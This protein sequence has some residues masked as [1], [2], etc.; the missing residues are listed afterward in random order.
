MSPKINN[1]LKSKDLIVAGAFAALYVIL[2][3][4]IVGVMGFMVVTYLA[5]PFV[6]GIVL[7]PVYMLYVTKVPKR[8]AIMI[9]A[10]LVALVTSIGAA[11]MAT[12]IWAIFLGLAAELIAGSGK[13]RS[14]KLLASSYAVFACSNMGPFWLLVFAKQA[15][16][17][18]CLTYYNP[19]YAS[20]I[21]AMTP[22]GF[23][24]V[25]II[26]AFAGGIIGGV[27]G[28]KLLKKHFVKAGVV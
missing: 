22:P 15:F 6:M 9:L 28:S 21:D 19:E 3:F 16:L 13:Y 27:L 10:V 25:L 14:R 23:I 2:L 8:G 17:D 7:G 5:A 1:K 4:V 24:V 12:G 11:W 26:L 18:A 20:Q